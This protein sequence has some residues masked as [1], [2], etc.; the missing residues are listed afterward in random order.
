MGKKKETYRLM[1]TSDLNRLIA[2]LNLI[3]ARLEDRL[4]EIEALRGQY[5]TSQNWEKGEVK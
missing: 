1:F 3:L 5:F 2:D 4:D